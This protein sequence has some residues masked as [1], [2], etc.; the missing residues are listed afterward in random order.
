[1]IMN[2]K[3]K[4]AM[5]TIRLKCLDCCDGQRNEVRLCQVTGCP[6]WEYRFGYSPHR[7]SPDSERLRRWQEADKAVNDALARRGGGQNGP[8]DK[9]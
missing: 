8:E 5:Q 3:P 1:M 7:A 6:L 2:A 4:T 9:R